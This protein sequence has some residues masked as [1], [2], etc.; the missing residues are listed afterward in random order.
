MTEHGSG[1]GPGASAPQAVPL[2]RRYLQRVSTRGD[3][4]SEIDGLR[5]I[6]IA[7]VI[8]HHHHLM[9]GPAVEARG[10][11]SLVVRVWGAVAEAGA[12]G[13]HIFFVVSGMILGMPFASARLSGGRPVGLRRYFL[14]RLSRLEPPYVINLTLLFSLAVLSDG[15]SKFSERVGNY[16]ASLFY[17]HNI[18]YD[19][20]SDV[21]FVAWSLEVEAQFYIV[22]PLIAALFLV[23]PTGVRRLLLMAIIV[24]TTLTSPFFYVMGF[25]FSA[26]LL[27][28]SNFFF[29]GYL[30]A[31]LRVTG[32][33][34]PGRY[35]ALM[36]VVAVLALAGVIAGR[37][38][39][40]PGSPISLEP[41][42]ILLFIW[43]ALKSCIVLAF[44][45]LPVIYIIG[46][47]CYTIYLY[48]AWMIFG[49]YRVVDLGL[50]VQDTATF[51]LVSGLVFAL[52][53][54]ACVPFFIF[55]ERPFMFPDW[56]ARAASL[57]RSVRQRA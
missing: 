15:M 20:W 26:S 52:V 32:Q 56:P 5:F 29:A 17:L 55:A 47:M 39:M 57:W 44:L 46:G 19:R 27:V 14:R 3:F 31:D 9:L 25:R 16:L 43:S 7:L 51:L 36:D 54:L 12:V 30:L 24:A 45:R 37:L 4:V 2:W 33:L 18:I 42:L 13:V 10:L 22:A 40:L 53:V 11:D 34:K 1:A 28:L 21:N 38:S 35:A 50:W 6:A 41:F 48:H 23:R 8:L 49:L